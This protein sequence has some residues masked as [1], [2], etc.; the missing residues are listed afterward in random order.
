MST[1]SRPLA[2]LIGLLVI[3]L[4]VIRSFLS[5]LLNELQIYKLQWAAS[6]G[7]NVLPYSKLQR[8]VTNLDLKSA[9]QDNVAFKLSFGMT[10][11]AAT[12]MHF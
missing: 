5:H 4:Q 3:G 12:F 7:I 11:T 9:I 2:L 6:H 8:Y 10:F 1:F